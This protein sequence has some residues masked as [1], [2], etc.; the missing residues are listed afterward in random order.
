MRFST[1]FLIF[2]G[3]ALA[4]IGGI[5]TK[6]MW[7]SYGRAVEQGSWPR[8]EAVVLSSEVEEWRHD[9][10]SQMEYRLKLL[11]GYEWEGEAMTGDHYGV[12][13]NPNYNKREKVE[14]IVKAF[15]VGKKTRV[16]VNP[17]DPEVSILRPDSKAAGYSIWFPILYVIGGLGIAVR[18]IMRG[19]SGR[20][21]TIGGA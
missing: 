15:P 7:E 8:V 10:F 9:E 3:L 21:G 12:R 1:V 16:Y 18:A 5:F 6:L 19:F 17:G 2:L 11:Y 14:E 13:G 4:G 20:K